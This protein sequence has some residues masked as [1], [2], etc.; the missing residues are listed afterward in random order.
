MI[1]ERHR[2]FIQDTL[3]RYGVPPLPEGESAYESLLAWTHTGARSQVEVALRHPI[4][5]LVNALGTPPR[6]VVD[7]VH[8]HGVL[9]A[10]LIGTA[11][12]ARRQ[13]EAGADT[14]VASCDEAGGRTRRAATLA[15]VPARG[16][17]RELTP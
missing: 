5:L 16:D 12:H 10:A 1:P 13:V 15:L 11:E 6:D 9:V 14:A 3:E 4:K 17:T 7:K 8:E 2:R